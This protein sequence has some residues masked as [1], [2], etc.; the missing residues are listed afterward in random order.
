MAHKLCLRHPEYYHGRDTIRPYFEGW[1]F[2]HITHDGGFALSVIPGVSRGPGGDRSFIQI[3]TGEGSHF[4]PYPFHAFSA[5]RHPFSVTV[6]DSFFS[7][8]RISLSIQSGEVTLTGEIGYGSL[9]PLRRSLPCPSIMGPFSYLPAMEC[10]HGVLSMG[11]RIDGVIRMNSREISMDR[12]IGYMEKDWGSA[13]PAGWVWLQGNFNPASGRNAA[14]TCSVADIPVG[15]RSF[16]GLI[17]VLTVDGREYRFA[18]YNG[19]RVT[20]LTREPGR[21]DITL[22]RGGDRLSVTA[23]AENFGAL[24]APADGDMNRVIHESMDGVL[25]LRLT[26]YGRALYSGTLLCAGIEWTDAHRLKVQ[27]NY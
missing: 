13:F 17:A 9:S 22:V 27:N 8:D 14:F 20:V 23:R 4:I 5:G 2:K 11:H 25:D 24:R 19:G 15:R 1:Y 16:T 6:G 21:M 12:G 3:I 10:C 18:T 7:L 26:R